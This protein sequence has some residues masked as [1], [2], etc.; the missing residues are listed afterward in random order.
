MKKSVVLLLIAFCLL[1][2]GCGNAFAKD[3]YGD[4]Q[5]IAA[6]D[7]YAAKKLKTTQTNAGCSLDASKLDGWITVWTY[8]ADGDMA[9]NAAVSIGLKK[10]TAK[11]VHID[12]SG[13]VTKLMEFESSPGAGVTGKGSADRLI[14]LSKGE[15]TIKIAGYDCE[16]VEMS[17]KFKS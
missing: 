15:N 2:S 14:R 4:D 10:G 7:H 11:V 9:V 16:E 6:S 17:V 1:F 8:S 3:E 5:K 12:G 13:K